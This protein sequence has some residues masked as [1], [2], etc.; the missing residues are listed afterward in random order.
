MGL[1]GLGEWGGLLH[2]RAGEMC[3]GRVVVVFC[4]LNIILL[5]FFCVF[6]GLVLIVVVVVVYRFRVRI[7]YGGRRR[8]SIK[9]TRR[10]PP[11][12]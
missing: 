6:L 9:C 7:A 10:D 4:Y 12:V 2:R 5:L 8:Y 3:N 1:D 11:G